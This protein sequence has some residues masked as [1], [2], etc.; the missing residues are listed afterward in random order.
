[1]DLLLLADPSEE[2]IRSYIYQAR[3]YVAEKEDRLIG[4]YVITLEEP[5]RPEIRNLAVAADFQ[6][7]GLGKLL[8]QHAIARA[9]ENGASG[10]M[11]GTGNSSVGQLYLYQ[12]MG[13]EIVAI[14]KDYFTTH[15]QEPIYENGIAC[16]HMLVLEMA[17]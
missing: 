2:M 7:Q 6:G 11:I 8:L 14:R 15:Y 12:K 16:K 17:L 4:V 13:F 1:M 10:L 3:I 9:R 5:G